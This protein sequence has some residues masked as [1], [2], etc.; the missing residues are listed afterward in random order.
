MAETFKNKVINSIKCNVKDSYTRPKI[1]S[2]GFGKIA[3]T[4]V[5]C[6]SCFSPMADAEDNESLLRGDGK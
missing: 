3:V 4:G 6:Q 2:I 1:V 5:L